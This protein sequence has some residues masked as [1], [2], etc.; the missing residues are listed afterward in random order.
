MADAS[1]LIFFDD[2]AL[3]N[4]K[5]LDLRPKM[6][7]LIRGMN[8]S[9]GFEGVVV[10]QRFAARPYATASMPRTER[11]EQFLRAAGAPLPPVV[12]LGFQDPLIIYYSSGTTGIPKAIVHGVGPLLMTI[13]KESVLHRDL[14]P[15]DVGL[16]YTTTGWIMYLVSVSHI[17]CGGR[18]VL[19]DGS[20]F[21]PAHD[22]LLRIA[23]QQ[24]V[25]VL[26]VSP[27]WMTELRKRNVVPRQVADLSRL[28]RVTSTGMVLADQLFEWFYDV[29]FPKHVH[30][31]NMSGG[32]DI[33]RA[34]PASAP[35][36]PPPPPCGAP[37][38]AD[39]PE[40]AGS[41]VMENPL[42]PVHVGGSVGGALG[43]PMAVFDHD[44]PDGSRGAPLPDGTP[45]DLV[46]TAAFPSV[47]LFLWGDSSPAPGDQYT[48]AYFARFD[49]AWAQGDFCV[50][51][52]ATRGVRIL[53]RSD[54][55]LNPSGVRFG[56]AD[57][58][59]VMERRFAA[60]VAESLCVGQRR[61]EDADERVVLF[62]VM[63]PGHGL[64]GR[65]AARIRAA[66]ADETS[67]RH[68]PKYVF[69]A[70]EIPVRPRAS[71]Q[72][73][74]RARARRRADALR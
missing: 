74:A 46:S 18:A 26:G 56:S 12:R 10:V 34:P 36:P 58:Y 41:F 48:A 32:T 62:V 13:K 54:G 57:I 16:Q 1:Q 27:R 35:L 71:K 29:A 66:I 20:P 15:D 38:V 2:A 44:L 51:D 31:G 5:V 47:P 6:Y 28:K 4:G 9:P 70:P 68:V 3:Y 11:L 14:G 50:V 22:V 43:M 69:E 65:L 61:A 23:E 45:G 17:M 63:R 25:T 53:G 42:L 64:D 37:L 49:G 19:Y 21:V 55:V 72:A 8:A 24:R 52:A 73:S 30:L 33:V 40:Q 59:A 67:K 60:E 39:G 7:S